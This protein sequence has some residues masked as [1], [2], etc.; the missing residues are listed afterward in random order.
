MKSKRVFIYVVVCERDEGDGDSSRILE[1]AFSSNEDAISYMEDREY[2]QLSSKI[3]DCY[4][5]EEVEL[6]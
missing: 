6:R 2:A 1:V 3:K 5:I 4:W